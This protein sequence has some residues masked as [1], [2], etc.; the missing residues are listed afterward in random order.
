MNK[1]FCKKKINCFVLFS[2]FAGCFFYLTSCGLDEYINL[3]NPEVSGEVSSSAEH[4]LDVFKFKTPNSNST[5]GGGDFM[6][7]GVGVYYRIF[8]NQSDMQSAVERIKPKVTENANYDLNYD[9][10]TNSRDGFRLLSFTSLDNKTIDGNLITGGII[11]PTS[12]TGSDSIEIRLTSYGSYKPYIKINGK[13]VAKPIRNISSGNTSKGFDFSKINGYVPVSNEEDC[14][15]KVSE[16]STEWYI[17]LFAVSEGLAV[18]FTPQKSQ[19]V[20]LGSIKISD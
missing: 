18:D 9:R 11:K 4:E 19:A 16:N 6:Y 3:D 12:T 20:Y 8:A 5:A 7:E 14:D 1:A 10:L 13:E 17:A 2:L 15:S